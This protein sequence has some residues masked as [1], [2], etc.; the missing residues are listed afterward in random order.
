M[1]AKQT[2]SQTL[3]IRTTKGIIANA[4]A[5]PTWLIAKHRHDAILEATS[6]DGTSTSEETIAI[7]ARSKVQKARG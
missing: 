4:P 3:S 5:S 6:E 1:V 7:I 2:G